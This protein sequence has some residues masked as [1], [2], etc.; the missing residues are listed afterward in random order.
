MLTNLVV[1]NWRTTA[2]GFLAAVFNQ[3]DATGGGFPSNKQ[4]W[5]R[6]GISAAMVALGVAAKDGNV[7]SKAP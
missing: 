7:G 2:I 5:I 1:G 4:E 6:T 3:L